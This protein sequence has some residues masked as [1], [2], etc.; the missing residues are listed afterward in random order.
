MRRLALPSLERHIPR[1]LYQKT[2]RRYTPKSGK[3]HAPCTHTWSSIAML[4]V[5]F[6]E[7]CT[8]HIR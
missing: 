1:Q 4:D 6:D 3:E 2:H 7:G 5:C 8:L